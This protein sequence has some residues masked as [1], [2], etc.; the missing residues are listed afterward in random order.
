MKVAMCLQRK[1]SKVRLYLVQSLQS[2]AQSSHQALLETVT[3]RA[4]RKPV[5]HKNR[6]AIS[7]ISVSNWQREAPR[8]QR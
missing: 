4:N 8:I 5:T 1:Q 3:R 2:T 7:S 6:L